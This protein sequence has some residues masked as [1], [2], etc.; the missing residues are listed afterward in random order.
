[1]VSS[2]EADDDIHDLV[3]VGEKNKNKIKQQLFASMRHVDAVRCR[4]K[5]ER[6]KSFS[7]AALSKQK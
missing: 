4:T 3:G 5:A 6:R 2:F 1:M 7:T